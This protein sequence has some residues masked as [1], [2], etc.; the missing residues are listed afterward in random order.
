MTSC[1]FMWWM[2]RCEEHQSKAITN[3][4]QLAEARDS[5]EKGFNYSTHALEG[6]RL[7]ALGMS[8]ARC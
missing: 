7:V 5:S 1:G 6:P 3:D 4:R 8:V 2:F